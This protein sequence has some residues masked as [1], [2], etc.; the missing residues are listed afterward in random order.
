MASEAELE[1]LVDDL[2]RGGFSFAG[3]EGE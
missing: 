3:Q 2:L 1:E